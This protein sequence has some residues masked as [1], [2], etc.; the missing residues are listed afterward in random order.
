MATPTYEAMVKAFGLP[1][2]T[3]CRCREIVGWY[4][5]DDETCYW[6]YSPQTDS[7]RVIGEGDW[8]NRNLFDL[9][10]TDAERHEVADLMKRLQFMAAPLIPARPEMPAH[11]EPFVF[12]GW[13]F[14]HYYFPELKRWELAPIGRC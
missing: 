11:S 3:Q 7:W 4:H 9:Q 2:A 6:E 12:E 8:F 5:Y 1:V 13:L 14:A 10:W